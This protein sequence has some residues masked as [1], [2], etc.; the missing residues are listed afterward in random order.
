[1]SVSACVGGVHACV[2]ISVCVVVYGSR[3]PVSATVL[4]LEC[5][6]MRVFKGV[7][8]YTRM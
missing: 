4:T 1:M 7:C 8:E 6:L 2:S 5:E 3:D